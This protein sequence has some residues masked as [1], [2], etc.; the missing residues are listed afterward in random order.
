MA[1]AKEEPKPAADI[2]PGQTLVNHPESGNYDPK[3][4]DRKAEETKPEDK[5]AEEVPPSE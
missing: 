4:H 3:V 2:Q 5:P 1:K